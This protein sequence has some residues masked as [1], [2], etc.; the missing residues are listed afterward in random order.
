MIEKRYLYKR[1]NVYWVRVRVPDN[2]RSIIGKTELNKNLYTTNLS[3]ANIRKHKVVAELKQIINL[4]KRKLDGT[5]D[6]LSKEDQLRE[7]AIEFRPSPEEDDFKTL[8]MFLGMDES[9][10]NSTGWERG[11]NE[12]SKL[13]GDY[14]LW[15]SLGGSI[16]LVN[17]IEFGTSGFNAL[18]A[19]ERNGSSF[20]VLNQSGYFWTKTPYTGEIAYGMGR[21]VYHHTKQIGKYHPYTSSKS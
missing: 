17:D 19:G 5:I 13:A 8:E 18:P 7:V 3:E 16:N 20:S 10:V 21:G 2:L 6:S 9:D 12:G 14:D 4:A 11:T 1:H 15:T